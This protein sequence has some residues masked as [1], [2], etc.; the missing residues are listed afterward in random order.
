M[1]KKLPLLA[2]LPLLGACSTIVSGS[3]QSVSVVTPEA[4]AANC[5]LQNDKGTWYVPSTPSSVMVK[6][7]YG[8][9]TV[10]CE[11]DGYEKGTASY[12]SSAK[13]WMFGNIIFGGLIGLAVDVGTGAG[14]EYPTEMPVAMKKVAPPVQT[15]QIPPAQTNQDDP[16]QL[17]W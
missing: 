5:K 17:M 13:G 7:A 9:M 11:K 16:R 10:V 1:R 2:L 12:K 4:Q 8:D 15:S 3:N 14:F 6:S